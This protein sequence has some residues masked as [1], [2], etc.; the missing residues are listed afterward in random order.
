M[1]E[2]IARATSNGEILHAS[3]G[4]VLSTSTNRRV[5]QSSSVSGQPEDLAVFENL[6]TPEYQRPRGQSKRHATGST[7]R[8]QGRATRGPRE[9]LWTIAPR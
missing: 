2:K 7:S 3:G 5:Q 4:G 8:G 9:Q 6:C 1:T